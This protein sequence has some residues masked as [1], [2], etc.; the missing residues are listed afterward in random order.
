MLL[1]AGI[2]RALIAMGL[3]AAA[4]AVLETL[5]SH[6]RPMSLDEISRAT[7]YARSHVHAMLRILEERLAVKRVIARRRVLYVADPQALEKLLASHI[8]N[9]RESLEEAGHSG[10][11]SASLLAETLRRLEEELSGRR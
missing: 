2:I 6:G 1:S 8:R 3:P 9:L 10:L 5:Y 4:A 11:R 7:G